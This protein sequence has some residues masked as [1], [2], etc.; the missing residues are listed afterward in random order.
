M[1]IRQSHRCG[2]F[3][4]LSGEQ[5]QPS[6]LTRCKV[7]HGPESYGCRVRFEGGGV[8][9][10][11]GGNAMKDSANGTDCSS[12]PAAGTFHAAQHHSG[13]GKAGSHAVSAVVA[14]D[15][16]DQGIAPG[17]YAVFYDGDVCL[18]SAVIQEALTLPHAVMD[19]QCRSFAC[20]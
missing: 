15:G 16:Q 14:L 20:S 11:G 5:P 2:P 7:R 6:H 19:D 10:G 13:M 17:Q 12:L 4:W 1:C 9:N 18:G 3:N 8:S